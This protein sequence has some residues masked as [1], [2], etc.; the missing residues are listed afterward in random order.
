MSHGPFKPTHHMRPLYLSDKQPRP[1]EVLFEGR[2]GRGGQPCVVLR[3]EY[4]RSGKVSVYTLSD[5]ARYFEPVH[6]DKELKQ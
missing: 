4:D 6:A 3:F 1:A 2:L 5:L